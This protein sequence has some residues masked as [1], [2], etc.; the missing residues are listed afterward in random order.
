MTSVEEIA[1]QLV[2]A[3]EQGFLPGRR[4]AYEVPTDPVDI[5]HIPDW[6]GDGPLAKETYLSIGEQEDEA[7]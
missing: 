7:W 3:N 2:A 4:A 6:P 1:D 5:R